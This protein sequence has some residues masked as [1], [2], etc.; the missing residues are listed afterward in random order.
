MDPK[1]PAKES[2]QTEGALVA[3]DSSI[4]NKKRKATHVSPIKES[5]YYSFRTKSLYKDRPDGP[6]SVDVHSSHVNQEEPRQRKGYGD[7]EYKK[8]RETQ[9]LLDQ[10]AQT[11]VEE[12][13]QQPT[14]KREYL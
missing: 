9:K 3:D 12:C 10:Q 5:G 6:K 8:I 13:A 4:T 11:E 2:L 14:I 1:T 7:L